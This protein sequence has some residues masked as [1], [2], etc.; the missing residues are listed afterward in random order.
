MARSAP[1][2]RSALL[3]L[4]ATREPGIDL[5]ASSVSLA[6]RARQAELWLP[7]EEWAVATAVCVAGVGCTLQSKSN[8][9][10][11]EVMQLVISTS[12]IPWTFSQRASARTGH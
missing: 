9:I 11:C 12:K 2:A 3:V 10:G 4:G 1:Q 7:D 8:D 5:V 6:A